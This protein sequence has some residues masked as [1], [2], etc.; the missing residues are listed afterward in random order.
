VTRVAVLDDYQEV[1]STLVDWRPVTDQAEVVV[2]TDHLA[3]VAEL[4]AR[5]ADFDVVVAMRERTPIGEELL[6]LLPKLRLIVTTGK[7][8]ASIDLAAA[9]ARGVRVSCTRAH[10]TD[11]ALLAELTWTLILASVRGLVRETDAVRAGGWQQGLGSGLTGKQLGLVGLGRIGSEVARIGAAF[12]MSVSA[13]SQN[14][15]QE[16][17][18]A[19]QVRAVGKEALLRDSDIVSIH[20]RLSERSRG[21]IAAP[22]LALMKPTAFLVNTARGPLVDEDDLAD[23]LR[24]RRIAGAALDAFGCEPLPADHP[25]RTLD[26]VLATPHIGYVTEENYGVFFADIVA[27]IEAFLAGRPI[28]LLN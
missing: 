9:T 24:S 20:L 12:G 3:D 13:W 6:D 1:A 19:A 8:N 10:E 18:A 5:L 7:A 15:T 21:V 4:A 17:A 26:N 28:R 25:F 2:F 22:E 23:A 27:D 11:T 14:L 16:Q